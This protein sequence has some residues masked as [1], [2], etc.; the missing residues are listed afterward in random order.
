[1]PGKL[2]GCRLI[3]NLVGSMCVWGG[4]GGEAD[5]GLQLCPWPLAPARQP[6]GTDLSSPSPVN[7]KRADPPRGAGVSLLGK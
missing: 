2:R 6:Q 5:I 3:G 4:G 7:V 1:M